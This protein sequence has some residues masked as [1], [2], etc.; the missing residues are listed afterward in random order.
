[1]PAYI[2][3]TLDKIENP[4]VF[5]VYQASSMAIFRQYGGKSLVNSRKIETLDGNWQPL[6]LGVVEFESYEPAK[7]FYH[8]PE[9]QNLIDQRFHSADSAVTISDCP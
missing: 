6:G 1:M 4:E 2:V 7:N 9:Y 8:S 3:A 5:A